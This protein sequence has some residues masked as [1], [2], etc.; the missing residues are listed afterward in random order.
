[1]IVNNSNISLHLETLFKEEI[2]IFRETFTEK[3]YLQAKWSI[4]SEHIV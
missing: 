4:L 1:M 3:K 2:N